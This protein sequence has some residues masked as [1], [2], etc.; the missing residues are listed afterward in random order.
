MN[1]I[2]YDLAV[3]SREFYA[4]LESARDDG[5]AF[6]PGRVP[7]GWSAVETGVWTMWHRP[8]SA[9]AEDGWKVHV[10]A[11]LDRRQHIL[12]TAADICFAQEVPFKHLSSEL[13]YHWTHQK[14]ASRPQ[15]GKFVAAYPADVDAARRLMERLRTELADEEGP[16][17]L[18]DRRFKDSRTVFYRYGAFKPR[19]RTEADGTRTPLVRDGAGRIVPD[20]R[21][22]SFRLPEGIADPFLEPGAGAARPARFGGFTVESA[23]RYTNAGGTYRGR[24]TATARR[25]FIKEARPLAGLREDGATAP[26]QLR[27][28]WETLVAL[29]ALAPGL[30]PEPISYFRAWEH[31]FM[32][33]E[34]VDGTP[35]WHWMAATHPVLWVGATP[36]AIAAY[37]DRC[38]KILAG[39]ERAL[40]RLH[41]A[42]YLFVDVSPGNVLVAADDT[43]RLVDFGEAHRLG[44]AFRPAGT[45]GYSPPERL[46]GE[47]LA[48]YDHYGVSGLAQMLVGSLNLV[49]Q[50]NP[51]ALAHLHRDL[52]DV[53]PV[54][55]ALWERVT[56]YH[57]PDDTPSTSTQTPM[58]TPEQ[59]AAD[60]VKHLTDLRD[61]VADALVAMAEVDHPDRIFPTIAQGYYTN[62][63]C[64]AYGTAGVVHALRRADQALPKGVLDRLRR[65]A[66]TNVDKLAPGLYVGSSGI[67]GVLAECGLLDEA[68]DLLAAADRHPLT[69][70]CATL[71]GGAAGV[72]LAHL[73]LYGHTRDEHHVDRALALAAALPPDG[74]LT[75]QLGPDDATGLMHGRCGIALMLQQ[76]AGATGETRHLDRA[77]RLLHA[78]L[79]RAID[80]D[81]P[82]LLFPPSRI[83]RRACPYVYVGS[84]G[85]AYT[86]TRCLRAAGDER[87][88]R[89]LP[90]LLAPLSL[91]YAAMPGLCQGMS[92][93][94]FTLADHAELAGDTG[95]RR[96]ALREA[97][98]L[99]KYAVPHPTGV[100]FLGDLMLRFSAELWSG[101][102][103]VLLALNQVLDPRPDALFTI[104]ALIAERQSAADPA[105]APTPARVPTPAR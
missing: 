76:L 96:N 23:V 37:C 59:V 57:A 15:S 69:G 12:D 22:V 94:A 27:E 100:R 29:H 72:A 31:E 64:V 8:G 24:E 98:R 25:V 80:P 9:V 55:P 101:S 95:A 77:V 85:M 42:G 1:D 46:V 38:E 28:E 104:D 78:E 70:E 47:D 86:V 34:L 44:T 49:V 66:L 30:A 82:G 33:T 71:Y 40:E 13:F 79:D 103:G 73:V 97:C 105:I 87:L 5:G 56:R 58:P 81:A 88:S 6:R 3:A 39:I 54:P 41:E 19:F 2:P 74:E 18:T 51:G 65:D 4:P 92:G 21:G 50:R 36:E 43:V 26:E 32:V 48:I 10:S 84:A 52:S 102:A 62:T 89:A 14:Y 90:Q 93:F 35:L 99:F 45:P 61:R 7:A 68:R 11:R 83:D 16:Y 91:P 60:P 75:T 53:A 67:A 63:L 20:L 17:I